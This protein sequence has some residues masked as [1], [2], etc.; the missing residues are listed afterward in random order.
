MPQDQPLL[1]RNSLRNYDMKYG[2][3]ALFLRFRREH[4]ARVR[5]TDENPAG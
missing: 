1:L 5:E 4:P 3:D 2:M